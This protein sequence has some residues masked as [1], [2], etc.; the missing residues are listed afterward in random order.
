MRGLL[1]GRRGDWAVVAMVGAAVF[2][3]A[4]ASRTGLGATQAAPSGGTLRVALTFPTWQGLDPQATWTPQQWELLRCCLLRAL[5]TYR[6]VAG[7]RGT[8]PV[9]DLA[10]GPPSASADGMTWTFR[11]RRGIQ[12]GPPLADVEVTAADV[13]RALMRNGQ[14]SGSGPGVVYLR[15]IEGFSE[16]A[17]GKTD[18]IAGV[19]TPDEFTLRVR[20]VRPDTSIAHLFAMSFTAPIPPLPGDRDATFG[21]AT[22]HPLTFGDDGVTSEGYGRFLVST[23]PYMLEGAPDLDFSVPAEQQVPISGFVPAWGGDDFRGRITLVSNPS[24]DPETDPNRRAFANRIE[25]AIAP[26]DAALYRDLEAGAVDV[27][28]GEDPPVAIASRYR[29]S[30][31]LQ[32]HI[33][34]ST[35]LWSLFAEI[36]VAQP[37]FD[38]PHV[39]RALAL[40]VDRPALADPVKSWWGAVAG[41]PA[42]HVVP[43]PME[44]SL[45]SQWDPFDSASG[46]DI[47]AAHAEMDASRYGHGGLCSGAACRGGVVVVPT[48]QIGV[49]LRAGLVPL[50]ITPVIRSKDEVDC[51]DPRSHVALCVGG[52][53]ADYPDAGNFFTGWWSSAIGGSNVPLLGASREEL[54]AWGY[55]VRRVPSIDGDYERCAAQLGVRASLCW[56]RLDQLVVGELAAVIP[57]VAPDVVRV[58]GP[59]VVAASLDQAFTE[60][61]LDRIATEP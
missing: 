19:V 60:P 47:A 28:M 35:G 12:Y 42:T 17:D 6:G 8:E 5:M 57:L 46:S 53:G 2:V 1:H 48:P 39:R 22:G 11:L 59:G 38:D 16:Y 45:L 3:T 15:V 14:E 56:A 9:P 25:I 51:A 52:Y 40:A 26:S 18:T 61:S 29:S 44:G 23:G 37:P 34:T 30:P 41:S 33:M 54:R 10:T 49:V 20:T 55:S 43:D 7:A 36:N 27:V 31:T 21:I 13:V 50:G 58:T 24:W 32:E 4:C